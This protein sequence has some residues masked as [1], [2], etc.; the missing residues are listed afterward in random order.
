MPRDISRRELFGLLRRGEKHEQKPSP[1]PLRV[2]L[3][4][5]GAVAE[6]AFADTC[7]RCGKC[8]DICPRECIF[9]LGAVGPNRG[10]PAILARHAPCVLCEGLLCTTV[11]PTGA[12]QKVARPQDVRMGLAVV[13]ERTCVTFHGQSCDAC[14]AACPVPGALRLSW[15]QPEVDPDK[16]TGCGL[17]EFN[18]PTTPASIVV[19]SHKP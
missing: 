16:C 12:L 19:L 2:W 1:S 8:I 3:R 13:I 11:C 9:P 4:P 14:H 6:D 15:A 5:P 10:T 18:C 17:C 7:E